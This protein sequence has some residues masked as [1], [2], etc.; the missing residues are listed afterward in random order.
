MDPVLA[1]TVADLGFTIVC[2]AVVIFLV[3]LLMRKFLSNSA[4]DRLD[5]LTA[6]QRQLDLQ[7][8]Q[9]QKQLD[10]QQSQI[11]ELRREVRK[12]REE[13]DLWFGR[14]IDLMGRNNDALMGIIDMGQYCRDGRKGPPPKGPS[15]SDCFP[16]DYCSSCST[17]A[18]N[19]AVESN[20]E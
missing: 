3:I 8:T 7:Q 9:A 5:L 18:S 1:K 11:S 15:E 19:A 2:G 14:L 13:K 20:D 6:L 17:T 10:L 12:M 16:Q 4:A